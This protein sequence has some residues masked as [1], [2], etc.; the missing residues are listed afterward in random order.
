MTER[1]GGF[2]GSLSS[3]RLGGGGSLLCTSASSPVFLQLAGACV[4]VNGPAIVLSD[5]WNAAEW[6]LCRPRCPAVLSVFVILIC[7]Q[8]IFCSS[9]V[10]QPGL[11]I[12][13]PLCSG[14]RSEHTVCM[15]T[16]SQQC[17]NSIWKTN[18]VDSALFGG[19]FQ[20]AVSVYHQ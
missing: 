2:L 1:V 15:W 11:T 20:G 12:N 5:C 13:L 18:N 19:E 9:C 3:S 8:S 7:V 17:G 16:K 10:R 6:W 14:P 4:C